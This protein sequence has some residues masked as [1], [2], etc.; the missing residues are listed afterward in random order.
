MGALHGVLD[1]ER[2][3]QSISKSKAFWV[4]GEAGRR[5]GNIARDSSLHELA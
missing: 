3:L 4:S 5:Y 2:N 1:T